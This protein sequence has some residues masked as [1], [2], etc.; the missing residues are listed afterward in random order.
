MTEIREA[1][2]I[3]SSENPKSLQDRNIPWRQAVE[4]VFA[5]LIETQEDPENP[6]ERFCYLFHNTVR[7]FLVSNQSIFQQESPTPAIHSIS[8]LT[9][10]NACLLYLS[11]E[12]YSQLLSREAEQWFTSS[13][14]KL[15][16]H[17]LLT[18]SAKYW[19]KHF[20][21]VE[22]TRELR[23]R[24]EK[25]LTSFN[26]QSSIQL[27]SLF[28]QGHFDVYTLDRGSPN[29]KFTKRVFPKWFASH[30]K[31]GCSQFSSN[32]RSYISEWHNLLDCA[33]CDKPRCYPHSV[34]K[35]FKGEL[36]RCLWGALGPQNFLSY[37]PGRYTSFML[38]N[39]DE[40]GPGKMPY[41]EA[42][43]QDGSEVMVL[44]LSGEPA[45]AADSTLHHKH[46]KL[47][48]R[49]TPAFISTSTSISSSLDR[50]RWADADLKIISFVPDLTILRIGF[51][52]FSMGSKGGFHRIDGLNIVSQYSN[53]CFED[54]ASRGSL[55][56]I[57]S[58]RKIPAITEPRGREPTKIDQSS[59]KPVP[60][61]TLGG[62]LA[63]TDCRHCSREPSKSNHASDTSPAK[64]RD[65]SDNNG[66][67]SDSSSPSDEISEWNSAEESWS[68]GS[69][70]VDELGNPLT[71]S[72]ESGSDSSE[73]HT[74]SDDERE[75]PQDDSASDTAVNSYG[76]LYEESDS[77]GG[78]VDFDCG[79][80]DESY[81]G[82]YES[83]WSDYNNQDEDLHFD[84]DDEERLAKRMAYSRPDKKHDAKVQQGILAIYDTSSSPPTQVFQFVQPLPIMLYDSP[85]A[86]HPTKPLVVWPLCGG[87]VLFADF[88]GKSYFV[89]RA[90][91]T[92]RKSKS[93][94]SSCSMKVRA[95]S[96]L[97]TDIPI[98][99][100]MS[101]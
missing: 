22:E 94:Y 77:D 29:Q 100:V 72:D 23:Q 84:S 19:D 10:A 83:D 41:H 27:Q 13:R 87:D 101:S 44:R 64:R 54:I 56:V 67:D 99:P 78:D 58:R 81:D 80:E 89:R 4:K 38:C 59:D 45:D 7:D 62:K 18:Y 37:Y 96:N 15:K 34:V 11:Q 31:D 42:I 66:S 98:K 92:T 3:I 48:N 75:N 24:I 40:D 79:S 97:F 71:S 25:F 21:H 46:W 91:T 39:K 6:G 43:S 50:K 55:L 35:Q 12:R 2:G 85:P 95:S 65:S 61:S 16:D 47:P 1:V 36:D 26:F 33:N 53:A 32:Y 74:D 57:S 9:I 69:T 68:E 17:H 28:V 20:D 82:D 93:S 52:M 14:D 86:I 63:N 51:Q 8:E 88:E 60:D 76:Q 73:A 49:E 90:R 5:P 30:S 70:E